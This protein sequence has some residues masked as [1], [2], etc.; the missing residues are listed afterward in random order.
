MRHDS[1]VGLL[2]SLAR[3]VPSE[4]RAHTDESR[5]NDGEGAGHLL[6]MLAQG[7][8]D[9]LGLGGL[10]ETG[11]TQQEDAVGGA[12][13]AED[14]LAEILVGGEQQAFVGDGGGEY[15]V[16][17]DAGSELGDVDDIV[18]L[19]AQAGD[20]AGLHALVGEEPHATDFD[21]G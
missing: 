19:G 2:G 5:G 1:W 12:I 15:G 9:G 4:S 13:E 8:G 20:D 7:G 16:V 6:A 3:P 10:R 17:T 14:E 21:S 18:P 11:E